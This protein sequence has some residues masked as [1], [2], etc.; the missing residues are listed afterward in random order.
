MKK[1]LLGISAS[2]QHVEISRLRGK[3]HRLAV[4]DEYLKLM[5][6]AGFTSLLLPYSEDP[7]LS[8]DLFP[9]LDGLLLSG[10]ADL[11]PSVW[12]SG[13]TEDFLLDGIRTRAENVMLEEALSRGIP[14][15]GICRGLQQ[16][17]AYFGGTLIEDI[18]A[19]YETSLEHKQSL[20][21]NILTHDLKWTPESWC[22]RAVTEAVTAVNSYHHQAV[23][24]PGE[25]VYI[26][27][28]SPDGI[29]EAIECDTK[30]FV[31]A[32]QFHPERMPLTEGV[33]Q[34]MRGFCDVCKE[35]RANRKR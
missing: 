31:A 22:G 12:R 14:V 18:P 20:P 10:G 16:I 13:M 35:F 21:G 24:K 9:L 17:N 5:S 32:V 33:Q 4:N 7:S 11:D 8:L 28:R 19:E 2:N 25:G 34:L 1:L 6:N 3:Q 23:D 26:S 15:F 29:I 27:G 30:S